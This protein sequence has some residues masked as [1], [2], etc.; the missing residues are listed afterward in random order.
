E[1]SSSEDN[2]EQDQLQDGKQNVLDQVFTPG[3][4]LILEPV[5]LYREID[6]LGGLCCRWSGWERLL[7]GEMLLGSGR[8]DLAIE[9]AAEQQ[10][11][12][13]PRDDP[14]GHANGYNRGSGGD[15]EHVM[16]GKQ[17]K[18]VAQQERGE[19]SADHQAQQRSNDDRD[20]FDLPVRARLL[21]LVHNIH[22][23]L[24]RG[25]SRRRGP[26]GGE[27]AETQLAAVRRMRELYEVLLHHR[28]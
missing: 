18:E 7:L 11:Q 9:L 5:Q 19:Y 16:A 24:N 15:V 10:H 8:L 21:H 4:I 28:E 14:A 17:S 1:T 2:K 23:V 25:K 3:N 26:D 22:R 6:S 12:N 27:Q 13:E 20:A